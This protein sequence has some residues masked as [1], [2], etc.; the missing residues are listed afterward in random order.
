MKIPLRMCCVCRK[1]F[2]QSQLVRVVKTKE[3]IFSIINGKQK[4]FGRSA[5]VCKN[6]ECLSLLQKK[7]AFN[8]A[9]KQEV[10]QK[11]YEELTKNS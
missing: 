3:N 8:R 9:F 11:I 10:P 1:M 2:P 4:I 7:R 6:D 5:Y